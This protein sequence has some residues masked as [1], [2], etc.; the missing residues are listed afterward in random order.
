M[1]KG[2]DRSAGLEPIRLAAAKAGDW[3]D[4]SHRATGGMKDN[5]TRMALDN[6][7]DAADAAEAAVRLRRAAL[8]ELKAVLAEPRSKGPRARKLDAEQLPE[9]AH[10]RTSLSLGEEAA[11]PGSG[12][13]ASLRRAGTGMARLRSLSERLRD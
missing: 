3:H 9:L 8:D 13:R 2:G 7:A 10:Y 6:A 12:Q 11:R 1:E 5:S 4:G